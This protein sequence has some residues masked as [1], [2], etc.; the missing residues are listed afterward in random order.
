MVSFFC[1]LD[2]GLIFWI[3]WIVSS[4]IWYKINLISVFFLYSL[5][6]FLDHTQLCSGLT[7]WLCAVITACG[8]RGTYELWGTNLDYPLYYFSGPLWMCFWQR[9]KNIYQIY[10]IFERRKITLFY[11]IL[12]W[13]LYLATEASQ[14][15]PGF[16]LTNYSYQC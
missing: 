8:L 2:W 11:F 9:C 6:C 5:F 13:G 15:T 16:A 12:F 10:S 14:I 3:V 1:I 4:V 7:S